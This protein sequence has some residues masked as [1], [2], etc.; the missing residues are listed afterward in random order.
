MGRGHASTWLAGLDGP[1]TV[2][3]ETKAA[4]S[5]SKFPPPCPRLHHFTDATVPAPPHDRT[6]RWRHASPPDPPCQ[7][8]GRR[9]HAL[10]GCC[11]WWCCWWACWDSWGRSPASGASPQSSSRESGRRST[12]TTRPVCH[13]PT[14][15]GPTPGC[16][17]TR[18]SWSPSP[19]FGITG[20]PRR[21]TTSLRTCL[22]RKREGKGYAQVL[23]S[24]TN[25]RTLVHVRMVT[26]SIEDHGE[27]CAWA[28]E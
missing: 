23:Y 7:E 6:H 19:R 20:V 5:Y 25:V 1:S 28:F 15:H 26:H 24:D 16:R 21:S 14:H 27:V 9:P 18:A 3:I 8:E 10:V 13:S 2:I 17:M 22:G 4:P 11:C 12:R